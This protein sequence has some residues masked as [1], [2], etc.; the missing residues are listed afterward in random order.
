[1]YQLPLMFQCQNTDIKAAENVSVYSQ[2][3]KVKNQDKKLH[4]N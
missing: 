1:M 3:K 2:N 4:D